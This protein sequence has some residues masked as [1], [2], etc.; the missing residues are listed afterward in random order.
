MPKKCNMFCIWIVY[1]RKSIDNYKECTLE[2]ILSL[3]KG[4]NDDESNLSIS[5]YQCNQLKGVILR[6][7]WEL[8]LFFKQEYIL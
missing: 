2:H 8:K 7:E 3:S 1:R 5:H 6:H 4:G